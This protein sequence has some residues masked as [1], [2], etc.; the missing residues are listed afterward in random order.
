MV[1]NLKFNKYKVDLLVVKNFNRG[2]KETLQGGSKETLHNNNSLDI[3]NNIKQF[4]NNSSTLSGS[5]KL[6]LKRTKWNNSNNNLEQPTQNKTKQTTPKKK[7]PTKQDLQNEKFLPIAQRLGAIVKTIKNIKTGLPRMKQWAND[8]RKLN[9]EEGVSINRM[10]NALDWYENNINRQYTPQIESGMSFRN[11][12]LKLEAAIERDR[13]PRKENKKQ[14]G[15]SFGSRRFGDKLD[16]SNVKKLD[17][18]TEYAKRA[19]KTA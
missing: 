6:T 13:N 8:I 17:Y 16:Y 5:K 12:F 3:K 2:S 9:T 14:T 4:N 11:K 15:A 10:E 1:N 19:Y 18:A 7:E